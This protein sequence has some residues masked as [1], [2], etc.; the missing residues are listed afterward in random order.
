MTTYALIESGFVVNI[1][2][3]DGSGEVFSGSETLEL[4]DTIIARIGDAV[5]SGVVYQKPSDGYE[6][7]FNDTTLAWELTTT[8]QTAKT[9]K[10]I[11]DAASTKAT[12]LAE[13]QS[14]ISLWQSEL[15][16]GSISD[17]DKASLTTWISYIKDLQAVDTTSLPVTWPVP[18]Q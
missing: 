11:L 8:G 12:L 10:E 3:W 2:V 4:S 1:I 13:A 6:Y 18:P 16:L 17:T 7:T 9:A 15:L 14:T 5:V